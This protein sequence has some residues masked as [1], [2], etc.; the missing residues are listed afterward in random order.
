MISETS[1]ESF[2]HTL[3]GACTVQALNGYVGFTFLLR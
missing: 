3:D 1:A 2:S